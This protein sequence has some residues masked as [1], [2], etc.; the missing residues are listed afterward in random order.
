MRW[1]MLHWNMSSELQRVCAMGKL[2]C[3]IRSASRLPVCRVPSFGSCCF[4]F[5]L[6][7]MELITTHC[8]QRL[9]TRLDLVQN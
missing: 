4:I 6:I 9:Y 1:S 2:P 5:L 8:L 3:A 7:I